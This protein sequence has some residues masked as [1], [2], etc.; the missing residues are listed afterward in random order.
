MNKLAGI[1]SNPSEIK[2]VPLYIE[3]LDENIQGGVPEGH[4]TL[5]SGSAGT[6]KSSISFNILYNEAL[7]GKTAVYCSLE[8]SYQSIIK[9]MINMNFDISKVNLVIIKDLAELRTCL[10]KLK[11]GVK[12]GLVMVDVGCIRKEIKD[13]KTS[14]NK[15]WMNVIKNVVK[16]IKEEG[17]CHLFCLDSLSALYVLSRFENPRIELFYLF[18]F[19]RDLE[20]T[21][22]LISE[23]KPD[24]RQYGEFEIEEF[25][26]DS[27]VALR[28]TPFRR[29]VVR[30][31]SVV[32][33]RAT[34]CNNDIFSLEYK[35]NRFQALYGGQNPLL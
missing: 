16:K 20:I 29:N 23:S 4:I 35:H 14:N 27:I 24:T 15:S 19:L 22:F 26:C 33:M 5:I 2:R 34:N 30:E 8:Q 21:S 13:V 31:I 6:M 9:Q 7:K 18:E 25:L 10:A 28:L 3:G 12:G 1:I 17:D 32:K 11:G